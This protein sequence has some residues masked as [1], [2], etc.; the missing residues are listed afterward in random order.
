MR[1]PPVLVFAS[2]LA[3]AGVFAAPRASAQ[4]HWD[5]GVQGGVMKR[6]L[7]A[8]P[9]SVSDAGFGPVGELHAHVALLPMLRTGAYFA[10]DSSPQAPEAARRFLAFGFRARLSPPWPRDPW[11]GW[12]FLGFGYAA[13]SSSA[14]ETTL[15]LA[16]PG[17][18]PSP[19]KVNVD[20]AD[21]S[22]FEI[23]FGVGAAYTFFKPFAATVELGNRFGFGHGQDLYRGRAGSAPGFPRFVLDPL[24]KDFYAISLSLGIMAEL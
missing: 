8:R 7:V 23:P 14:Y 1:R 15:P 18:V 17:G 22:L 12:I 13:A 9:S 20:E 21:G 19:T 24:G 11:R 16:N 10:F 2:M 6:V 5:V 4:L 3:A